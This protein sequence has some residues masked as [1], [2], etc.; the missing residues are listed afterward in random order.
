[1]TTAT[2]TSDYKRCP[3]CKELDVLAR[4]RCHPAWQVWEEGEPETARTVYAPWPSAAAERWAKEEDRCYDNEIASGNSTVVVV[5]AADGALT[6][7]RVS[8]EFVPEY[9]ASAVLSPPPE[10]DAAN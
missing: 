6:R 9:S 4:H 5:K 10:E 8:G 2:P 3:T 1:M 7:W